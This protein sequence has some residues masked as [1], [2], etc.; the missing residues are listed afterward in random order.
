MGIKA[1]QN[2]KCSCPKFQA[3]NGL[4]RNEAAIVCFSPYQKNLYQQCFTKYNL[5]A[6]KIHLHLLCEWYLFF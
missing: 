3:I 4:R 2:N 6:A 1:L 5:Q